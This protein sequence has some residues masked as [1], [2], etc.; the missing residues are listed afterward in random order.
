M[1]SP[2]Q[3]YWNGLPFPSPGD[4]PHPGME[5]GSPALQADS[6]PSESPGKTSY[7]PIPTIFSALG[8]KARLDEYIHANQ[9]PVD[10][11]KRCSIKDGWRYS[12]ECSSS[13]LE[14]INSYPLQGLLL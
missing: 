10:I 5:P 11:P 2:R 3:E 4:V 1:G 6:L 9:F 14:V 8:G 7:T 12:C 13:I